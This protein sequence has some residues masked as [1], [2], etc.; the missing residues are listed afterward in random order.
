MLYNLQYSTNPRY[1]F[2]TFFAAALIFTLALLPVLS[3]AKPAA[4]AG[5]GK[6]IDTI[7]FGKPAS[8]LSHHLGAV[9]SGVING[10]LGQPARVLLPLHPY[11]IYGGHLDFTM[12]CNPTKTNYITVKYWGNDRGEDLG[13]LILYCN[14]LQVGYRFMSD[15]GLISGSE[16]AGTESLTNSKPFPGRFF[17]VTEPL[18]LKLTRNRHEIH[19]EIQAIGYDWMYASNFRSYQHHLTH[20]SRGIYKAYIGTSPF[21]A[22]PPGDVQGAP[23]ATAPVR[24]APG[25]AILRQ[26]KFHVNRA[27]AGN[28]RSAR[29]DGP[30]RVD[31]LA[32]AYNTNWCIAYHNPLV[33]KRIIRDVDAM[34][35]GRGRRHEAN[36]SW[37]LYAPVGRAVS[38]IYPALKP[39]LQEPIQVN[40]GKSQPRAMAWAGLLQKTIAYLTTHE[41]YYTN[42]AM[43]VNYNIYSAN[44]GLKLLEPKAAMSSKRALRYLYEAIGLVRWRGNKTAAGW[45]WPFGHHYYEVTRMGLSRE[46]GY[47]AI[48]GETITHFLWQM[49]DA[50]NGN[51]KIEKQLIKMVKARGYFMAPGEDHNGYRAMRLEG[52][53]S[54]RHNL[55]PEEVCYGDRTLGGGGMQCASLLGEKSKTLLGYAQQCLADNQYFQSMRP[56]LYSFGSAPIKQMLEI[57]GQYAAVKK[58]PPAHVELPMTPGQPDFAWADPQDGVVVVKHDHTR[59]YISLYYRALDGINRL[60]R[61][62]YTTPTMDRLV[63][64]YEQVQFSPSGKYF[65]RPDDIDQVQ[66]HGFIPP[67]NKIHNAYAGEK[68]PIPVLPRGYIKTDGHYGPFPRGHYGPYLGRAAFYRLNFGPYL[69][70][71]NTSRHHTYMLKPVAGITRAVNL[72]TGKTVVMHGPMLIKPRETVVLLTRP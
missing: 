62:H 20:P 66:F 68:L 72:M 35:R 65:V 57:P 60:A 61:I 6:F 41:R 53:I 64:A 7:T 44:M 2:G 17:Y 45:Q 59:L 34:A 27:L 12:R 23:P 3:P 50:T 43:I 18:P 1:R 26:L 51:P 38:L 52:V 25:P 14:G 42:Q 22:P 10:G 31:M 8:E 28:L 33:I 46:L 30:Q 40:H 71:M 67:G 58:L 69:I 15:Y 16:N 37:R 13:R 63:R 47:V 39:Y 70:G 49:A 19:L 56:M 32:R 36:E 21:F 29:L 9:A 48:Y 5:A 4:A 54:W 11:Q 55:Y 24:P